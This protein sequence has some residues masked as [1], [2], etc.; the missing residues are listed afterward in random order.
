[1][2]KLLAFVL[3]LGMA[4]VSNAAVVDIAVGPQYDRTPTEITLNVSDSI[5]LGLYRTGTT[6]YL[7]G[8]YYI[9][10]ADTALGSIDGGVPVV[11][12]GSNMDGTI[13]VSAVTYKPAS[14]Y[15]PALQRVKTVWV[16]PISTSMK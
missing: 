12:P 10:V 7:S 13:Q 6:A 1:M 14:G 4:V 15:N 3:L 8:I 11:Y 9:V 16:M 5:S 2:K